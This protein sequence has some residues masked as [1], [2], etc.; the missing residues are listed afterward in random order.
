[1]DDQ[2]V[3]GGVDVRKARARHDEVQSVRSDRAVKQ[4]V[5]RARLLRAWL[6]VWIGER[7]H[8]LIFVLRRHAIGWDFFSWDLAPGIDRQRLGSGTGK[9]TAHA[10][11]C[12]TGKQHAASKQRAA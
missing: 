11:R 10:R 8:D 6:A 1:M 9:R 12:C 2:S 3:L 5:R 7:P 4:M